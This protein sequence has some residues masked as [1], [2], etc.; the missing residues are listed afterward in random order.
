MAQLVNVIAPIFTNEKGLFL[1]TL[2]FP[3]QL[4]S[5]NV[6]GTALE[7]F[8]DSPSY[9]AKRFDKVPYLDVSA[10]LDN[11]AVVLN[12]VNRH[13]DQD[14]EAEIEP[15]DA[16]F[17]GALDVATVNGPALKTTNGFGS[18]NVKT[19]KSV[20]T[21]RGNKAVYRFPAHSFTQIKATL[22]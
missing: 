7:V 9:A 17:A 22:A 21:V 13:P 15:Q 11:G 6:R 2:Y 20:E 10:S 16:R 8:V 12:V 19:V 3:L 4:F 18:E 5:A 1:Q 14:I